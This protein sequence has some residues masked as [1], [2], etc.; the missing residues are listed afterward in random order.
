ML[1]HVLCQ[2]ALLAVSVVVVRVPTA[3]VAIELLVPLLLELRRILLLE[4]AGVVE[5]LRHAVELA[6]GIAF[7][8]L[9]LLLGAARAGGGWL[10]DQLI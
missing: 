1:L 6:Q 2:P 5:Y 7:D 9:K 3:R 8:L 10:F 4:K